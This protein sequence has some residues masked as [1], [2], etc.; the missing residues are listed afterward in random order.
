V[1]KV[2]PARRFD[3]AEFKALVGDDRVHLTMGVVGVPPGEA[4][5]FEATLEDV[6]VEVQLVGLKGEWVFA[7]LMAGPG[8]MWTVPAVG[9]EVLVA[10]PE[11]DVDGMAIIVGMLSSGSVPANAAPDRTII[12]RGKVHVIADEILL[13]T[14]D[15]TMVSGVVVGAGID[16]FTGARYD[17]LNN[18]SGKVKAEK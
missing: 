15:L 4:T 7:R 5:H 13:G 3:M 14:E 2:R 6:L 1:K 12:V 18:A 8:G 10:L 9:E 16:T 17:A 11:G